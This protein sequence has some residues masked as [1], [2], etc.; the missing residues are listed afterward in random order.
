MLISEFCHKANNIRSQKHTKW[1]TILN[2]RELRGIH[3]IRTLL[4]FSDTSQI[5]LL[6]AIILCSRW[7]IEWNNTNH[8]ETNRTHFLFS[9]FSLLSVNHI[10]FLPQ[11]NKF[12]ANP[13]PWSNSESSSESILKYFAF[14]NECRLSVMACHYVCCQFVYWKCLRKSHMPLKVNFI[15]FYITAMMTL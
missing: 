3:L 9:Y 15:H 1:D 4:K 13:I 14:G 7:S 10:L 12:T 5:V 2:S 8:G 11:V 6:L